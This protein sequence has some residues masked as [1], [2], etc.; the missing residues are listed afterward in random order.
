VARDEAETRRYLELA[1]RHDFI[2]GVVGVGGGRHPKLVGERR[3][4]VED[5]AAA[6]RLATEN[7]GRKVAITRLGTPSVE[8]E[9]AEEWSAAME[10]AAEHPSIYCKAS[11][12][13][14]LVPRPWK[15]D[16]LRPFMRH[17]LRA[18]GPHRVMFGSEWPSCLP[19]SIW[20]EALA[21]F[22][23][24]IGAQTMEAREELLGGTAGRFYG[25][26]G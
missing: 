9:G 22:T 13:L 19:E 2:R 15:A 25:I 11:G 16:P 17:V 7:P 4:E 23:Q 8:R 14:W 18:F 12:L 3:F 1:E 10:R 24:S 20:K 6:L 21:I 5:A 26:E